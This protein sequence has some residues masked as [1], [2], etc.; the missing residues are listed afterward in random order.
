M[1]VRKSPAYQPQSFVQVDGE[2]SFPGEYVLLT[3]GERASDLIRRAGG[4]TRMAYVRGGT[5]TR[6]L[7]EEEANVQNAILAMT[8]NGATRDTL[9]IRILRKGDRITVGIELDK[10]LGNPGSEYDPILREGDRLFVPQLQNTVRI[11]GN[12]L[13]PNTVTYVP[14]KP[15]SYYVSAAGGYGFRAKRSKTYIVYQNGTVSSNNP[16]VEPGCEIIVPEK[17]Q[18]EGLSAT[19]IMSLTTSTASLAAV[20]VSIVN[21]LKK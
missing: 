18:R 19:Q 21:S 16:K 15:V 13:Y 7:S 1:S 4:P 2:V 12:V 17:P 3:E 8:Q 6:T 9:N 20:V 14:G 10:A 11:S 5:L